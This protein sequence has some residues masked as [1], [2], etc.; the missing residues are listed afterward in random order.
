MDRVGPQGLK[1][2]MYGG[3]KDTAEAVPVPTT[4]SREPIGDP[5][6]I[7]ALVFSLHV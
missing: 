4:H 2:R 6:I 3:S 5:R 1:P 7:R